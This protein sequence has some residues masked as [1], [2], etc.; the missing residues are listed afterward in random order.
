M[1]GWNALAIMIVARRN[2]T[3]GCPE[4]GGHLVLLAAGQSGLDLCCPL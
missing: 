4:P 2:F 3:S 1:F